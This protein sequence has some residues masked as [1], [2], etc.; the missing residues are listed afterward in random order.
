MWQECL[1]WLL[2]VQK[3]LGDQ[4]PT[5]EIRRSLTGEAGGLDASKATLRLIYCR[6]GGNS[7]VGFAMHHASRSS[8]AVSDKR[9]Q[10]V[11]FF[12]TPNPS[13]N[14]PS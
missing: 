11:S 7:N 5:K 6:G 1:S 14:D 12:S 10:M 4:R 9:L 3:Q 2:D 13:G 8:P